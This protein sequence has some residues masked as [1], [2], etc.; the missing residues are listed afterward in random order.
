MIFSSLGIQCSWRR[1]VRLTQVLLLAG[2]ACSCGA[3][4][5]KDASE[6]AE[7]P[8]GKGSIPPMLRGTEPAGT[9]ITP[10]GN[11]GSGLPRNVQVLPEEEMVFTDPDN[12]DAP[13]ANFETLPAQEDIHDGWYESEKTARQLAVREGKP[14]LIWFTDS[15]ANSPMCKAVNQELFSTGPYK[16]WAKD[17]IISLRVDSNVQIDGQSLSDTLNRKAMIEEYVKELRQRFR[18]LGH[19]SFIMLNPSGEVIGRYRGYK[20]GRADFF[21]GQL[22]HATNVS[23]KQYTN[24][25]SEMEKKGYRE[26]SDRRGRTLFAKLAHYADGKVTFIEPNGARSKTQESNLSNEDQEWIQQ[27][28][29]LRGI[30]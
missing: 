30:E 21:W 14:I 27:Q 7:S 11:Q 28:K 6:T 22:K 5:K 8:F 29:R 18:I 13:I 26:W 19:P 16:T 25:R 24:W 9:P 4:K 10:G 20:R 3:L 1:L 23:E 17:K 15:S 2:F 12:P